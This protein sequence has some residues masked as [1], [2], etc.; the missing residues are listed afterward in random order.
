MRRMMIIAGVL[1]LGLACALVLMP[2]THLVS[3]QDP[4]PTRHLVTP[5][6][7]KPMPWQVY[8]PN[9]LQ[10]TA[11]LD[12][13]V[14]WLDV[15]DHHM[16]GFCD[17]LHPPYLDCLGYVVT[18]TLC[19][20]TEVVVKS[21]AE[22]IMAL[23]SISGSWV[24]FRGIW[25]SCAAYPHHLNFWETP[26]VVGAPCGPVTPFHST[27]PTRNPAEPSVT[28]TRWVPTLIIATPRSVLEQV[29][30]PNITEPGWLILPS[31][32]T[33]HFRQS[34]ENRARRY[35]CFGCRW[36]YMPQVSRGTRPLATET[37]EPPE[38]E[39]PTP[40]PTWCGRPSCVGA[41]TPPP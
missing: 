16:V 8:L 41:P 36:L 4:T 35:I 10:E 40:V 34:G 12:E 26:V 29:V 24:R 37:M 6:L 19:D 5:V 18:V 17:P 27:P 32:Q 28:P 15:T 1:A 3:A 14:G 38:H 39:S 20:G 23:C 9:V 33:H 7:E 22:R 25:E 30:T 2:D 31:V 21:S 11:P 13:V